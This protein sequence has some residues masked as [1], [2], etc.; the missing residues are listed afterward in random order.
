MI[1]LFDLHCDT[2]VKAYE[3]NYSIFSNSPLHL[4]FDK[5]S[6]F[7]PFI[8]I[9]AIWTN[10]RL[11]DF[12]GFYQCLNI[13]KWANKI[14]LPLVEDFNKLS[15]FSLILS[16]EDARIIEND[17]SR[18]DLL[19]NQKVRL[20]TPVWK[21]ASV[22]GGAWNTNIG[23]SDFGKNAISH[24]LE[25]GIVVDVSHSSKRTFYEILDLCKEYNCIPVATHSNSFSMC[26][27]PRNLTENQIYSLLDL[28]SI[29]G[30]S[31]A[32]EH[33]SSN[34]HACIDDVIRHIDHYLSLGAENS[35]CLGCDFDG[36]SSLPTG[37]K[38]VSSLSILFEKLYK[39][40]GDTI[41]N[42]I[43]YGNSY[44]FFSK[45]QLQ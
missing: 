7:S 14:N 29:I 20:I 26:N 6:H 8:Q 35:I 24:M 11:S 22:I 21:D 5:A 30:I 37:I 36:I 17:L 1:P 28:N 45:N 41:V 15:S 9:M 3:E 32:P 12:E 34:H 2:L 18:I 43:F 44:R 25:L 19:Y 10:D 13:I 39:L 40:Y 27:H 38:D 42:K 23:L 33:L 31:L 4:S 16:I